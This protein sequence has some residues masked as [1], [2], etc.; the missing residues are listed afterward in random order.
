MPQV[1]ISE[2]Y[3]PLITHASKGWDE[4]VRLSESTGD[5]FKTLSQACETMKEAVQT[6]HS[7]PILR[8]PQQALPRRSHRTCSP[9]FW[10]RVPSATLGVIGGEQVVVSPRC[11]RGPRHRRLL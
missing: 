6:R 2:L 10:N 9:Y 11:R 8:K 1:A 7:A 4:A 5:L 3:L